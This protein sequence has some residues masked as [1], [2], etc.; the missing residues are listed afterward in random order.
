MKRAYKNYD[1][2]VFKNIKMTFE[3][4]GM[5]ETQALDPHEGPQYTKPIQ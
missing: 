1:I 2:I 3:A 5:K 4:H